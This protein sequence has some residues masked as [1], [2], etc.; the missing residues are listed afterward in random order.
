MK[1]IIKQL[2]D[3]TDIKNFQTEVNVIYRSEDE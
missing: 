2:L 1:I 3:E